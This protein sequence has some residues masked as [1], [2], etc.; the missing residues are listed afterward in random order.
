[1]KNACLGGLHFAS[2]VR[3][4]LLFFN[5]I[6]LAGGTKVWFST[7]ALSTF[8]DRS[9]FFHLPS[10]YFPVDRYI[11]ETDDQPSIRTSDELFWLEYPLSTVVWYKYHSFFLR[12][13][14]SENKSCLINHYKKP[15]CSC[16]ILET[17]FLVLVT[18]STVGF[19]V[20]LF[21][22]Q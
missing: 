13:S 8:S 7:K 17:S 10:Q 5:H 19:L 22:S 12:I 18:A 3:S 9:F 15:N 16:N 14:S 2:S 1:M 21:K 20:F 6:T 4:F 11:G